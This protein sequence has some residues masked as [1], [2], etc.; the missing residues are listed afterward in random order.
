MT[1]GGYDPLTYRGHTTRTGVS[2]PGVIGHTGYNLLIDW[3][4]NM[5]VGTIVSMIPAAPGWRV[6]IEERDQALHMVQIIG[7][8]NVTVGVEIDGYGE[9]YDTKI[10]PVF[11]WEDN[12]DVTTEWHWMEEWGTRGYWVRKI[13]GP[14]EVFDPG[15]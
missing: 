9:D 8:A 10:Y 2:D 7:W 3:M 5:R 14:G 1:P 4:G 15:T 13:L 6:V 12:T 11:V